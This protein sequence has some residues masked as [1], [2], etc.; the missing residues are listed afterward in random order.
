MNMF[1]TKNEYGSGTVKSWASILDDNTREQA[2]K[3]SRLSIIDGHISLMPDAHFGYGPPVGTVMLTRNAVSPYSVGVDIGCGMIA[4]KTNLTRDQLNGKEGVVLG[5]IRNFIPSGVGVGRKE[6][7]GEWNIFYDNYGLPVG[8]SNPDL[9]YRK[10]PLVDQGDYLTRIISTQYGTLGAGNHFVEVAE[11]RNGQVWIIL[12]SGSRGIGNLLATAHVSIAKNFCK[13]EG[14]SL[15]DNDFAYLVQGTPEFDNYIADMLWSQQYAFDNRNV[16]MRLMIAALAKS[17]EK[18][19]YITESINCH[20]NY[21]KQL[22]AHTWI[23]RK[24]AINAEKGVFGIIPGSMGASTYIVE[25]LG[26]VEALW[27]APHG[28]GRTM[29]RNVARKT[30]SV[31]S[32]KQQMYGKIWLDRDA[33][34][35]VDECP[36]AYKSIDQV[37]EDS[38]D[39]VRTH[40][41]LSQF[42]NYKGL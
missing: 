3:I 32:F 22:S 29:S 4:A 13:E 27:S 19:V 34:K 20:H 5:N 41:V 28:A 25:G 24:G 26:N 2:E 30:I 15:E 40:T 33:E 9:V 11:D 7:L 10:S 36:S 31:D 18:G 37:M 38:K 21:S 8:L 35:L 17:L 12:H 39:L 6:P 23:T 16:M 14:I 1:Q 42:I